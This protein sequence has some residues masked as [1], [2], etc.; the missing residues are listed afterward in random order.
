MVPAALKR[1]I[2]SKVGLQLNQIPEEFTLNKGHVKFFY[3]KGLYL[4]KRYNQLVTEMKKRGFNP[5]PKRQFPKEIF[6][7]NLYN[8]WNPSL[9]DKK[10]IIKRIDEK[11]RMKPNWYKKTKY[12]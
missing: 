4:E 11:I 10:I 3:N 6:L 12:K 5:N 2:N 9:K 1:T 8:D 7:P